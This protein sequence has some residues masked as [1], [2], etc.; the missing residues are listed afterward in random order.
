MYLIIIDKDRC[1]GSG[2]CVSICLVDVFEL[3]ENKAEPVNAEDCIGC[4]NCIEVCEPEAID[5]SDL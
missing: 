4:Q 1:T 5:I 3:I 2:P